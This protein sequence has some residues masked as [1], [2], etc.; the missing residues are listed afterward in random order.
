MNSP[1]GVHQVSI[2]LDLETVFQ[3]SHLVLTF[4]VKHTHLFRWVI[5]DHRCWLSDFITL[6][7]RQVKNTGTPPATA[8]NMVWWPFNIWTDKKK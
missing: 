6:T 8:L 4:K 2:Q 5:N 7:H 1:A 3:F